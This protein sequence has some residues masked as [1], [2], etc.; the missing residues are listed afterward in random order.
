MFMRNDSQLDLQ[1]FYRSSRG[2][3]HLCKVAYSKRNIWTKLRMPILEEAQQ[4]RLHKFTY[5]LSHFC[6]WILYTYRK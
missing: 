5:N 1:A 3:T 6:Y 2:C 4:K